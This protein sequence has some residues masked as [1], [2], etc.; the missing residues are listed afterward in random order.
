MK[1]LGQRSFYALRENL[2][3]WSPRGKK[4]PQATF[5]PP[6]IKTF[7]SCYRTPGVRGSCS[8]KWKSWSKDVKT[9]ARVWTLN[10]LFLSLFSNL[11]VTFSVLSGRSL[12][13][14]FR[15]F[16]FFGVRALCQ[17]VAD[18]WGEG[19]L[20]LPGQV[21][22]LTFLPSFPSSPRENGSYKN[23]WEST[24][25]SQTSFFQTSAAF[26]LW[27]L[28]LLTNL[29]RHR[30][31][32]LKHLSS[33]RGLQ[34]YRCEILSWN[35]AWKSPWKM[36]WNFWCNF[37]APFSSGNEA[38]KCP[39]FFTTNFTPFFTRRFAAANAQFW[40]RLQWGRSN[41]VDPAECRKL[42]Y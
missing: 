16:E 4:L 19:R 9:S 23:V 25:K 18:V 2:W 38:R 42:V 13:S 21:W 34:K 3:L 35:R 14:L 17:V 29:T 27:D 30:S 31:H 26:W 11:L 24:W 8:R 39:E 40:S 10:P 36:P 12:E 1:G 41:L 28:L 5:S 32:S 33:L 37:A 6:K 7:I 20:G 22:E 15:C